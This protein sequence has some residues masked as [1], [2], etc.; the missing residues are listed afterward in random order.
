MV[1][2]ESDKFEEAKTILEKM[3]K[4]ILH[5]GDLGTGNSAKICNNMLLAISMIGTCET[6]NLGVK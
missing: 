6:M 1:G 3:G 2:G 4:N 5:C